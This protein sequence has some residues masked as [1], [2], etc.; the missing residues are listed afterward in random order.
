MSTLEYRKA[1][2]LLAG[3]DVANSAY[4]DQFFKALGATQLDFMDASAYEGATVL[5]DLNTP[6]AP[7]HHGKWSTV[8]DGGT[9]EHVFN[10]PEAILSCMNAV[11]KG[12]HFIS[13]TPWNNFAGH[14]FYQ[15]SPELFYR[16]FCPENGFLVRRMLISKNGRW[17]SVTDPNTLKSRVEYSGREETSLYL[18]AERIGNSTPLGNWPQQS[19]Y[20]SLWSRDAEHQVASEKD[21]RLKSILVSKFP[22]LEDIQAY[23]RSLKKTWENRRI[24][25]W[26]RPVASKNDVPS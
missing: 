10:F 21:K 5:H 22:A 1:M 20:S 3:N 6:L 24:P 26:A 2:A 8:F 14:G 4:A 15:F 23:W 17:Y 25:K 7:E 16:I 18:C 19:D 11:R 9:L 13:I 12:G